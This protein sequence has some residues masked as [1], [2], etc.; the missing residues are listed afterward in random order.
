MAGY[1]YEVGLARSG[2]LGQK[3]QQRKLEVSRRTGELPL[4]EVMN[5][6][7]RSLHFRNKETAA[8]ELRVLNAL[9]ERARSLVRKTLRQPNENAP[10]DFQDYFDQF[11][12]RH[13]SGCSASGEKSVTAYVQ[14][15]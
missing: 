14:A 3:Q 12:Q 15:I 9:K 7:G 11:R 5:I 10:D 13:L 8:H 6:Y 1:G 4:L 2:E